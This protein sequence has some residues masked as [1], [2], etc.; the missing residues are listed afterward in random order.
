MEYCELRDLSRYL[1]NRGLKY[2]AEA[3]ARNIIHQIAEGLQYMH[4]L[5]FV[6]R[7]LKPQNTLVVKGGPDWWIKL[8]DFGTSKLIHEGTS[9]YTSYYGDF[10]APEA[11]FL[12]SDAASSYSLPADIWS[13]GC[14]AHWLCTG[15]APF[16][17]NFAAL[18]NYCFYK[19]PFPEQRLLQHQLSEDCRG[20]IRAALQVDPRN[21]PTAGQ[22]KEGPWLRVQSSEKSMPENQTPA[23]NIPRSH[24][25]VNYGS[26]WLPSSGS[27]I[28]SFEGASAAQYQHY[29]TPD[30]Q[31]LPFGPLP[32]SRSGPSVQSNVSN[33]PSYY[34]APTRTLYQP[35]SG[36]QYLISPGRGA[37]TFPHQPSPQHREDSGNVHHQLYRHYMELQKQESQLRADMAQRQA[38]FSITTRKP[39]GIIIN[40]PQT[41][42]II[43]FELQKGP[44]TVPAIKHPGYSPTS[45]GQLDTKAPDSKSVVTHSH[46]AS[47]AQSSSNRIP[48]NTRNKKMRSS[49]T[50]SLGRE[51]SDLLQVS[52]KV[53]KS[54]SENDAAKK[55]KEFSSAS[56][57]TLGA[58]P[59][60]DAKKASGQEG[61]S[62][63]NG[64]EEQPLLTEKEKKEP[65]WGYKSNGNSVQLSDLK[66]F[67]KNFKPLTPVPIDLIPII[68]KDSRPGTDRKS[69]VP[70]T[71]YKGKALSKKTAKKKPKPNPVGARA[72]QNPAS[73]YLF[74]PV[75]TLTAD[76]PAILDSK[77]SELQSLPA[78]GGLPNKS[79][80]L[81][82]PPPKPSRSQALPTSSLETK[83]PPKTWAELFATNASS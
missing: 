52:E 76:N 57:G 54:P 74:S 36:P 67:S 16:E 1:K 37:A 12:Q 55:S 70:G 8:A 33:A 20:F 7:D 2:L 81:R 13:L 43:D 44:T 63:L 5:G 18:Q 34:Y 60:T 23:P 77:D 32:P 4:M 22:A 78:P 40:N 68:A 80:P 49:K 29:S 47:N 59:Q 6:H 14:F 38:D 46:T 19:I 64:R 28:S 62:L 39:G 35:F 61:L 71:P 79:I 10:V 25:T 83:G 82:A 3:E 66:N 72:T 9:A 30:F 56:G 26:E 15:E 75:R 58:T 17:H 21:R 31:S 45:S 42:R 51:K 50:L 11:S 24:T 48:S 73:T 69:D 65:R 27:H 53:E 41:G